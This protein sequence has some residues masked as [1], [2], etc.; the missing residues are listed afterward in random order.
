MA[1]AFQSKLKV[2][3]ARFYYVSHGN[4][5]ITC[6]EETFRELGAVKL[7]PSANRKPLR[8]ENK[9][10]AGASSIVACLVL[11]EFRRMFYNRVQWGQ[12]NRESRKKRELI[13][14]HCKK[15]STTRNTAWLDQISDIG[16][17]RCSK[18]PQILEPGLWTT[19]YGLWIRNY[20]LIWTI[21]SGM[22]FLFWHNFKANTQIFFFVYLNFLPVLHIVN[23]L[24]IT[25]TLIYSVLTK[26]RYKRQNWMQG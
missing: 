20:G 18:W 17:T 9:P 3:T 22:I 1:A 19:G 13:G 12:K 7:S 21:N 8:Y 25:K 16:E 15:M 23:S 2:F 14:K 6:Y 10:R 24:K 4:A 26:M 5:T 11:T